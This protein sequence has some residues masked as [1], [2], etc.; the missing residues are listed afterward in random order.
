MP[1]YDKQQARRTVKFM[2]KAH[3]TTIGSADAFVL[4]IT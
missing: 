4:V 2:G 3:D 1:T